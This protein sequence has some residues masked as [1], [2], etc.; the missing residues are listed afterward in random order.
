MP[1]SVCPGVCVPGGCLP[2]RSVRG[3]CPGVSAQGGCLP[4][5]LSVQR[6][7]LP[8]GV[9]PGGLW[10]TSPRSEADNPPVDRQTPVKT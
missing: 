9:Y 2:G 1:R 6:G 8:G 4:R 5:G 3:V 7:C 10:Q